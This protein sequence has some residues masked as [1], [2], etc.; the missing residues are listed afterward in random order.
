MLW[1]RAPPPRCP[2]RYLPQARTGRT[3]T[4]TSTFS[5]RTTFCSLRT[6]STS[7][8]V[9]RRMLSC[10]A[11]MGGAGGGSF[12]HRLVSCCAALN[13]FVAA[14]QPGLALNPPAAWQFDSSAAPTGASSC[15][16]V[17]A[18]SGACPV[19]RAPSDCR[20]AGWLRSR[21]ATGTTA[22]GARRHLPPSRGTS[23]GPSS[24]STSMRSTRRCA[25]EL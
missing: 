14:I 10:N 19:Y 21:R 18:P 7:R 1:L 12:A 9:R 4:G 23:C 3:C 5:R 11:V 25:D 13:D 22:R 16:L 15:V 6:A 20:P 24:S 8:R 2:G 17:A